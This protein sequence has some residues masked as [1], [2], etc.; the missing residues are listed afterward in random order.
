[1]SS[2]LRAKLLVF[3]LHA[4]KFTLSLRQARNLASQL[5]QFRI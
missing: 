1:M 5:K 2:E 4:R 3:A